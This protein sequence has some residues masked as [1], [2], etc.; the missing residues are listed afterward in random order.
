[1]NYCDGKK[2]GGADE[3][4]VICGEHGAARFLCT[5]AFDLTTT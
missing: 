3:G 5:I 1:M 4:E 2:G